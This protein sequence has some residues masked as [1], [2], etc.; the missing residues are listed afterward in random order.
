[1]LAVADDLTGAAEIAAIGHRAGWRAEVMIRRG[2]PHVGA[3]TVIDTDTRLC[4]PDAAA[5]AVSALALSLAARDD[6]FVFKKTDS[7]LRGPVLAEV[8][9]LAAALGRPRV[10]LV[11]ANPSLGRV[12]RDGRYF[13]N[14]IPL[15]QTAFA[16]D[17]HHPARTADVATLLGTDGH[18]SVCTLNA[19]LPR[20]GVIVA[21]ATSA[22]D[23]AAW[24]QRFDATMLAAGGRDFFTA[25]LSSLGLTSRGDANDF[26]PSQPTLLVRGSLASP[27]RL[28]AALQL[29]VHAVAGD[30]GALAQWIEHVLTSLETGPLT[31]VECLRNDDPR[32]PTRIR[33]AFAELVRCAVESG[34]ARHIMVEGGAT[35]A[36][37][38]N[39]LG[40]QRLRVARE[41]VPGVVTLRPMNDER[42]VITMKPG[43]YEWPDALW[44]HV[45]AAA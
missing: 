4:A 31:A 24:A 15:D 20:K 42:A 6:I 13:V 2:S 18:V 36:S 21:A 43:S 7:V 12:I 37:I 35:A 29:P 33:G 17:P 39:V 45:A 22:D 25:L 44:T 10:L 8:A 9:A 27:T 16:R 34:V 41:W 26:T 32:A 5:R 38:L 23:I 14:G 11:P 19:E 28:D 30:D 1:M 40:W 3:L